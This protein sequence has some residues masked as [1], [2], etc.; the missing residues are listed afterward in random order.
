MDGLPQILRGEPNAVARGRKH[1][2][3]KCRAANGTET[4]PR[5]YA[6]NRRIGVRD[7]NYLAL[8]TRVGFAARGLLYI[9]LGLLVVNSG[10]IEGPDG[11]LRYVGSGFGKWLLILMIVGFVGY[12]LWRLCDA[13]L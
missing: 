3:T 6:F 11:V 4:V 13:F 7:R 8:M 1:G 9:V 2:S 5:G 10:R 12:G